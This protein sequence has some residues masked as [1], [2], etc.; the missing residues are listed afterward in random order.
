MTKKITP[1]KKT[2]GSK[3]PVTNPTKKRP[4]GGRGRVRNVTRP[5]RTTVKR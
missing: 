2:D 1:A 5:R 3:N 4:L